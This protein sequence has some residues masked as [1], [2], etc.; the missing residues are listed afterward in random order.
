MSPWIQIDPRSKKTRRERCVGVPLCDSDC[1][2]WFEAC[3][4]DYTCSDNWGDIKTWNWT[5]AGNGCKKPCKT[6]K[7]YYTD[8]TT[9][10]NKLFNYSFKYT[11]GKPGEDCMVMWPNDTKIKNSNVARKYARKALSISTGL[12]LSP[13]VLVFVFPFSLVLAMFGLK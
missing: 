4:D 13:G 7:E 10:C 12:C 11:T 8:P 9:F 3:K 5:K 1:D 2:A 6:F